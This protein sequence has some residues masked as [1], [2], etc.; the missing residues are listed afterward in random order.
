MRY[1]DFQK[2]KNYI[3]DRIESVDI[4]YLS[5]VEDWNWTADRI[6]DLGEFTVDMNTV[7]QLLGLDGSTWA[8]PILNVIYKDGTEE[9]IDCYIELDDDTPVEMVEFQKRFCM[10]T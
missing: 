7:T 1:Y 2:A 10:K 6:F 8:T 9:E 4:A 3:Q 5:M